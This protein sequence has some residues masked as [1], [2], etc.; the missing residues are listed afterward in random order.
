MVSKVGKID[1]IFKDCINYNNTKP[2]RKINQFKSQFN[3]FN[4]LLKKLNLNLGRCLVRVLNRFKKTKKFKIAHVKYTINLFKL[5]A[6][7]YRLFKHKFLSVSSINHCM[8]TSMDTFYMSKMKNHI[9]QL[10]N[11]YSN[12]FLGVQNKSLHKFR[13]FKNKKDTKGQLI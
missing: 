7:I 6:I 9:L 13:A 5:I 4:I 10:S 2:I 1:S 11:T 8:F 3:F 12:F